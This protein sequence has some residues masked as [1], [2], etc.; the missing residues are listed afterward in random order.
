MEENRILKTNQKHS[1]DIKNRILKTNIQTNCLTDSFF[2][3]QYLVFCKFVL[4]EMREKL[5]SQHET[6]IALSKS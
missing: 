6:V 2:K 3:P 5:R 1:Y 4:I